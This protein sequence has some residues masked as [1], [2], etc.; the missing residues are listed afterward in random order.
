MQIH[1]HSRVSEQHAKSIQL[2]NVYRI[3]HVEAE[4]FVMASSNPEKKQAYLKPLLPHSRPFDSM[5]A[6]MKSLFILEGANRMQGGNLNRQMLCRFRHLTTRR[7]LCVPSS[8]ASSVELTTSDGPETIFYL[9]LSDDMTSSISLNSLSRRVHHLNELDSVRIEH[10]VTTTTTPGTLT[11]IDEKS[12]PQM[13]RSVWLHHA[14]VP[15]PKEKSDKPIASDMMADNLKTARARRS[16][17][18]HT[19]CESFEKDSFRF[20]PASSSELKNA[21]LILSCRDMLELYPDR[22]KNVITNEGRTLTFADVN[23][24]V[25]VLGEIIVFLLPHYSMDKVDSTSLQKKDIDPLT[26]MCE[27]IER[28]AQRQHQVRESGLLS[29]IYRILNLM[30][31]MG[32]DLK[33]ITGNG[34]HRVMLRIQRLANKAVVHICD[35]NFLN[36]SYSFRKQFVKDTMDQIGTNTGSNEVLCIMFQNNSQMLYNEVDQN[37]LDLCCKEVLSKGVHAPEILRFLSILCSY[38]GVNV[39]QNQ[40][41]ILA[42]LF[43]LE[44]S[45]LVRAKDNLDGEEDENDEEEGSDD[46]AGVNDVSQ[47]KIY[48]RERMLIET[49]IDPKECTPVPARV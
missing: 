29:L 3:F 45:P 27:G 33:T 42:A 16:M 10:R 21:H 12:Q 14:N 46:D 30:K 43:D 44:M 37:L 20:I 1:F 6:N 38:G 18:F 36:L 15:K 49:C 17:E 7:Y 28:D 41:L 13:L 24:I 11:S 34:K 22:A 31:D 23:D 48:R 9:H 8:R 4:A 32:I 5:N 47:N 26:F 25:D 40:E 39:P 35:K 19:A 2:G